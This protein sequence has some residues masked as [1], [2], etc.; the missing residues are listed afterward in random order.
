V[1]VDLPGE[2]NQLGRLLV[3]TADIVDF[4]GDIMGVLDWEAGVVCL[5][6]RPNLV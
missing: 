1:V 4:W 2:D 3:H 6:V 5:L